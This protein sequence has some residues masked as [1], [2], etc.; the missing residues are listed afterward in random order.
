MN[1]E[2]GR[3]MLTD[4]VREYANQRGL[5]ERAVAQLSD[6]EV[7][8]ALDGESNSVAVLMKHVGGNLRSRW[9]DFL[10]ADGEKADRNRDGEFEAGGETRDVVMTIWNRGFATLEASLQSLQPADL[11][12]SITIRGE[13]LPVV[14]ALHRNLAHTSQHCGQIILLAKHWRGADWKTLSIPRKRQSPT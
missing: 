2:L 13:S 4:I 1:E 7:F 5:A 10:T 6:E 8:R 14:Q 9:T 11:Q 12:K 3:L